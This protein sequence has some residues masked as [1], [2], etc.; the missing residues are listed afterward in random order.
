MTKHGGKD[1]IHEAEATTD[2]HQDALMESATGNNQE[3]VPAESATDT[4]QKD[5]LAKSATGQSALTIPTDTSIVSHTDS[6][7]ISDSGTCKYIVIHTYIIHTCT[8][9]L[10]KFDSFSSLDPLHLELTVQSLQDTVKQLLSNQESIL[11]RLEAVEKLVQG[12]NLVKE[13]LNPLVEDHFSSSPEW[14]PRSSPSPSPIE[15]PTFSP[16]TSPYRSPSPLSSP[17]SPPPLPPPFPPL[18]PAPQQGYQSTPLHW[19]NHPYQGYPP[20]P[21]YGQPSYQS[22]HTYPFQQQ[23]V[24]TPPHNKQVPPVCSSTPHP[25]SGQP[26]QPSPRCQSI[27]KHKSSTKIL[28]SSAIEKQKLSDPDA[29]IAKYDAYRTPSRV[30]TLAQKLA[31]SAYFGESVLKRCTVMGFRDYPA[32]PPTELSDLKQKIFSLFPQ[33]WANPVEFEPT[34]GACTE[35]IGQLCKRLRSNT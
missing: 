11:C 28:S 16:V 12:K 6:S 9:L 10:V 2:L 35:S 15:H 7:I 24:A 14:S 32:L 34:W 33:F 20:V 4:P 8:Y 25:S 29:I 3:D 5:V 17:E 31:K 30:P 22:G 1:S 26:S 18:A 27:K 13:P 19:Q 21:Y 23:Y